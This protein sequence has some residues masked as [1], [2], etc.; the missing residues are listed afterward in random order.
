MAGAENEEENDEEL[1]EA[2]GEE[3]VETY[4]AEQEF[5]FH[6]FVLRFASRTVCSA[7]ALL[8]KR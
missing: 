1:E 8:L 3:V 7:Y 2:V 5:D 6:A 4:T